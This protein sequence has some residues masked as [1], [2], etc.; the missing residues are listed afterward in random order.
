MSVCLLWSHVRRRTSYF[1]RRSNRPAC[2]FC[3]YGLWPVVVWTLAFGHMY[4]FLLVRSGFCSSR[5]LYIARSYSPFVFFDMAG[6][7]DPS[8]GEYFPSESEVR[9][10]MER[11]SSPN[12]MYVRQWLKMCGSSRWFA[13]GI[14]FPMVW[15]GVAGVCLALSSG[16]STRQSKINND[17]EYQ[18]GMG[19]IPFPEWLYFDAYFYGNAV[20]GNMLAF[21]DETRGRRIGSLWDVFDTLCTAAGIDAWEAYAVVR[22]GQWVYR[23][24]RYL[25]CVL[26]VRIHA[27]IVSGLSYRALA[28]LDVFVSYHASSMGLDPQK[29][30]IWNVSNEDG[31]EMRYP[32]QD[33][34]WWMPVWRPYGQSDEYPN[35]LDYPSLP[36]QAHNVLAVSLPF[37]STGLPASRRIHNIL[38]HL[39]PVGYQPGPHFVQP[40]SQPPRRPLRAIADD[41][42]SR[43]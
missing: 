35:L 19:G 24:M 12:E 25:L 10:S 40:G 32:S 22:P 17:P 20:F 34:W 21:R 9:Q 43:L 2:L 37:A 31:P 16:M 13:C 5:F 39:G 8:T 38:G 27:E 41:D 7:L 1:R 30:V 26:G 18:H 33:H 42:A 15:E 14:Y 6:W 29:M 36:P 11:W 23:G 28:T 3:V 4:A